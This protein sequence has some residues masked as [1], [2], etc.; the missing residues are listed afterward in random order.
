M[1]K[2]VKV[3]TRF[4]RKFKRLGADEKAAALEEIA[5]FKEDPFYSSLDTHSLKDRL[6]GFYSFSVLPNLRIMFRFTNSGQT[7]VLFYDIGS[8]EIYLS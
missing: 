5:L 7:E 6:K 8:H 3:T 2:N 4:F 1:I